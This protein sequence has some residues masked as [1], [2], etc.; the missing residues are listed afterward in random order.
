[1]GTGNSTGSTSEGDKGEVYRSLAEREETPKVPRKD[2][3][4][5]L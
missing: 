3:I 5:K 2:V 4:R 1:M